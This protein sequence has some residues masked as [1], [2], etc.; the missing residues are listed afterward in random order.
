MNLEELREYFQPKTEQVTSLPT[1]KE[2]YDLQ[3]LI[4][5]DEGTEKL[6]VMLEGKI[7][8]VTNLTEV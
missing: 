3:F 8:F 5:N 6:Y 1:A 2:S 7:Y 4:K